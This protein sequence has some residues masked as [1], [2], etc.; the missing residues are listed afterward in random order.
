MIAIT[1]PTGHI[2]SRV[3]D[4]LLAAGETVRVVARD[5]DRLAPAVRAR[6]EVVQGSS[7]DEAVLGKALAGA[8]ALFHCVP[9]VFGVPDVHEHYLS[10]TRPAIAAM[11]QHGVRRVVSV[12]GI[13]RHSSLNAGVVG[14]ALA[15][16]VELERAGFDVRALWCPGF[17]DNA[18]N[19]LP[20]I[21]STGTFF[22]VWRGD[23]KAPQV[24]TRDI[25]AVAARLLVDDSWSGPGGVAVLGPEDLSTDDMAAI[26][27]EVLE[28]PVRYQQVPADAYM[29]QLKQHGASEAMAQGLVEMFAAKDAG[30]DD[31]EPRTAENTTPTTFR[32]WCTEVLRPRF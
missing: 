15:K 31:T 26:L 13:G 17:M 1:T 11:K 3:V 6:V 27:A 8:T 19:Y 32:Q 21:R 30:L 2:G 24:A 7:D 25:G 4:L 10:F 5:P 20:S 22:G 28:R 9:P 14:S 16:D 23:R 12:S 29:A 18:L